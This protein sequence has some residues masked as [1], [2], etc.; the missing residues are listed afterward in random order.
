MEKDAIK[1]LTPLKA[2]R[3]FCLWC[4]LDQFHEVKLCPTVKCPLHPLRL[5]KG[6]KGRGI[7]V[8]KTILRKCCDCSGVDRMSDEIKNCWATDCSLFLFRFGKRPRTGNTKEKIP[9]LAG[10]RA[11]AEWRAKKGLAGTSKINSTE[12]NH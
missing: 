1:K 6:I 2:V 8:L 11:L 7:S 10:L 4:S 3:K 12:V 5:G 9:N